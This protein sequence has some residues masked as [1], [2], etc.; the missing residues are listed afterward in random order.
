MYP[1][2]L[3]IR[4]QHCLVV[5]GG[6]VALRK[7][8]GLLPEGGRLTV[9]APLPIE[10]LERLAGEGKIELER[11]EY[12]AGEAAG[13]SLVFAATDDRR[14]NRQVY[15]DGKSAGVWVNVADDPEL[16]SFQ[17]PARVQ[18]G[19]FQLAIA[20]G[21]DAPFVVRRLRQFMER[22][23]GPEWAEWIASAARFRNLVRKL[24]RPRQE[25]ERS[26]ELFFDSTVDVHHVT[27]RVPSAREEAAW[28]HWQGDSAVKE[29]EEEGIC[30]DANSSVGTSEGA[31]LVSLIGAGPGDAG[32]MTLKGRHRL[33]YADAVVYDH[34]AATS[35]PCDLPECTELHCVGKRAGHHPIPQE[36]INA[37]LVRLAKEGKRV[38]RLKGGDPYVFG[39]GGEEAEALAR[40]GIP[41]EVIPCIT[42][43][44][45]APAYAGIPVT[46]RREAVRVTL[47]TAHE[48][49]KDQGPQ[50]RWDLLAAD[51]HSTLVGYMGVTSLPGVV[52]R[53]LKSGMSPDTPA[54]LVERGTTSQQRVVKCP[55]SELPRSAEE[56]RIKP[57]SIF[58]IG[59]TIHHSEDLDWFSR[60]PLFGE[61]LVLLSPAGALWETLER[62]GVE[63]VEVPLPVTP[64][65]RVVMGALPLTGCVLSKAYEVDA[66][67]EERDRT[68]WSVKMVAW[69]LN[70]ET[71]H[72]AREL[73]WRRVEEVSGSEA[74][75][76]AAIQKRGSRPVRR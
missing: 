44:V 31:G 59:P 11:R 62:A 71:A 41:F 19:A 18:R 51:P 67:E 72:R 55:L 73:G 23:F 64:A 54:A 29:R 45:A 50:V 48:S 25:Q 70:P 49:L 28:L 58:V 37:L 60:R 4:G 68:G 15:E 16:C 7:V 32:L 53:L 20:S 24:G 22:R 57:P 66:L 69:C 6:G 75:L 1:V 2:M 40:E 65:S 34:L 63:L 26:Y 39:R 13:Y 52:D 36:E 27:A 10:A 3:D 9:V 74:D 61:R 30:H 42:S 8:E 46:H 33:M 38:A 14:V 17:L 35:L 47:V 56:A 5:G 21:G 12:A 43:G 76:V